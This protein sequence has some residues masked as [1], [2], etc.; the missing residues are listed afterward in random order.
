MKYLINK[1]VCIGKILIGNIFVRIFIVLIGIGVFFIASPLLFV[2]LTNHFGWLSPK[3]SSL[4]S[5]DIVFSRY[6]LPFLALSSFFFGLGGIL[7]AMIIYL[8]I[9]L[10]GKIADFIFHGVQKDDL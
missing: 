9:Y 3:F 6:Y 8:F 1:L 7:G 10:I 2:T 5:T 4:S